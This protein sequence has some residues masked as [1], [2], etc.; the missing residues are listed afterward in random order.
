MRESWMK[1]EESAFVFYKTI[2]NEE[3]LYVVIKILNKTLIY[4]NLF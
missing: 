2:L 3:V 1:K 4:Q